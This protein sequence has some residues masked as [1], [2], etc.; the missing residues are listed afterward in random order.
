MKSTQSKAAFAF[1][2]FILIFSVTHFATFPGSV[3][4]F[5][6]ITN[7]QPLL[8]LKPEFSPRG[9]YE[10]LEDFGNE[11]RAAY[12]KLIPTIDLIFPICAFIFFLMFGRLAAE[13]YGQ[14]IYS[15]YYWTLPSIYL[16]MDFMENAF[17]V[18]LLVKYPERLDS[19]ASVLGFISVTKRIFMI[20]SIGF[21]LALFSL[22]L[23]RNWRQPHV[24]P[25]KKPPQ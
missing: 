25:A 16:L 10:R 6:E 23:L 8:D 4:Y 17:I 24:L 5:K 2:I 3:E 1:V 14:P 7:N 9:V 21:P 15:R 18:L 12:L 20:I 22:S 13:K 11:G 19:I